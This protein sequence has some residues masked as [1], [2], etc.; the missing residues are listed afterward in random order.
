V[1]SARCNRTKVG[2]EFE[3]VDN[4]DTTARTH[5]PSNVCWTLSGGDACNAAY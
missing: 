1:N 4:C 5:G 2:S 3:C